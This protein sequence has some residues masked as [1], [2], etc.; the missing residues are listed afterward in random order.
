[1]PQQISAL[2]ALQPAFRHTWRQL[3]KPFRLGL[4]ARLALVGIATGDIPGCSGGGGAQSR[5]GNGD[6]FLSLPTDPVSLFGNYKDD[7]TDSHE[8][9]ILVS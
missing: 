4:W 9:S 6:Q 5:G 8:S 1:M 7:L 2:D 3:F